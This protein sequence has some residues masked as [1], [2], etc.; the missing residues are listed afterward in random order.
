MEPYS[1]VGNNPIYFIDPDGMQAVAGLKMDELDS[2]IITGNLAN[3]ATSELQKSVGDGIELSLNNDILEYKR[4]GDGPLS[5]NAM[6]LMAAIDDKN[7][8][9]HIKASDDNFASN[10]DP[11]V[12]NQMGAKV[13]ADGTATG[14]QKINPNALKKMDEINNKPGQT[15]MHEAMEGYEVGK[16]A[17]KQGKDIAP[18]TM[19]DGNNPNSPYFKA[20]FNRAD[21]RVVPQSGN[22]KIRDQNGNDIP[23]PS[24]YL[25]PN[26]TQIN[27]LTGNKN[28]YQI[29]HTIDIKR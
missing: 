29:F 4:T 24:L 6:D 5:E 26:T 14:L 9:V 11:L 13:N 19:A 1:Y 16:M 18:A 15:T 22:I 7:V 21:G 23:N 27:Y 3:E 10:R 17:F 20:H 2:V 25:S 12:G 28:N 8:N